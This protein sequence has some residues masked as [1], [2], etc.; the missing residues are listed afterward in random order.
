MAIL[1]FH[2]VLTLVAATIFQK[3]TA[4]YSFG[5]KI[6]SSGLFRYLPPSVEDL[7]V[8]AG[9]SSATQNAK[10]RRKNA[11]ESNDA[12]GFLV[13]KSADI[14]LVK[15][16]VKAIDVLQL[17]LYVEYRWVVD[18]TVCA[19]A[20]Y[21]ISEFY[22][23]LLYGAWSREVNLSIIWCLILVAFCL[24][25]LTTLTSALF[26]TAEDSAERSVVLCFGA[27]YF[28]LT[29][30]FIMTADRAFDVGFDQAYSNFTGMANE[31]LK[32]QELNLLR[33]ERSPIVLYV[34]LAILFGCLAGML[35]FPNFRYARMYTSALK[36]AAE[37][38]F[39]RL[40]LHLGFLSPVFVLLLW[41]HP[42][43]EHLVNG[44]RKICTE[45]Q[46]NSVRIFS[47]VLTAI[48]RYVMY[49]PHL[50]AHLNLAFERMVEL[51]QE[52]GRMNSLELQRMV[53]RF[54]SYLCA[55]ALQ[56]FVPVLLQLIFALMLKTLGHY[57]WLTPFGLPTIFIPYLS[58]LNPSD[59]KVFAA[60]DVQNS[61][62]SIY[63][64][65]NVTVNRGI[66][67]FILITTT[68]INFSL[69]LIG[70]V[71]NSRFERS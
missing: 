53:F 57:S 38:P 56:Y 36:Y 70:V 11:R 18:L 40:F 3:L 46:L 52:A 71:Y 44:P 64:L 20:V 6:L 9:H 25:A 2:I 63:S 17:P 14:A 51:K 1:G 50:Q 5:R 34:I 60:G 45:E 55:A 61:L 59:P 29:M 12:E 8:A 33:S 58:G 66:W 27:V 24:R 10:G 4:R 68:A 39:E 67:T 15:V 41:T 19:L 65:F 48:L 23:Y 69:S 13:P 35:V 43:K 22:C 16:P 21:A 7:K 28:L 26:W 30:G 42:M 47:V 62:T 37:K 49:R 31:F 54:F 32:S